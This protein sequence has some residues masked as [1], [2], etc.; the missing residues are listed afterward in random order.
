MDELLTAVEQLPPAL[1]YV[2]AA[3]VVWSETGLIVGLVMP[4]EATL[5]LV[6]FLSYLGTLRLVPATLL[7]V[8]A[9]LAGDAWAFR[10]GRRYGPRVRASRLGVWVGPQRWEKADGMLHRLGGRGVAGA[11]WVAFVRTLAPRLAGSAGMPYRR[12]APWNLAG[13]GT[14]VGASV[15]AGYLAGTSYRTVSDILGRATGAVFLLALA[16]IAILLVG[17][18]L[19]RN[20]DPVRAAA[21]RAAA[22]PPVRWLIQRYGGLF[23]L[24]SGRVGAGWALLL[25]LAVGVAGLFGLGFGLGWMIGMVVQHSGLSRVDARI[26]L[27]FAARRTDGVEHAANAV[28]HILKGSWLVLVV[29]AVALLLGWRARARGAA[30]GPAGRRGG[31]AGARDGMSGLRGAAAGPAGRRDGV[32]GPRAGAR[33][34]LVTVIGTAGA[35]L[36]LLVLALVAENLSWAGPIMQTRFPTQNTVATASL[37]TIAWLITRRT[38]WPRIVTAWTFAAVAVVTVSGARL[39]LGASPASAVVTSVLIGV[40]WTMVFVVAWATRARVA[41]TA[42]AGAA[43]TGGRDDHLLNVRLR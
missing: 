31:V 18:W 10:N 26:A 5:L 33:G 2:V 40:L 20:P 9:A 17:R 29:A 13:V 34:D 21:R 6:G 23:V 42:A 11:R 24:L 7:M 14:W 43:D 16:V 3:L 36:P 12:F 38:H 8:A 41:G 37:C 32:A 39:Y 27:W 25:N 1:I 19:G 22:L 15:L 30:A 35:V 4:G 28:V